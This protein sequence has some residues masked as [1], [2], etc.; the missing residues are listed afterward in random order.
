MGEDRSEYESL[1]GYSI[2]E[3]EPRMAVF[4]YPEYEF[5][6]TDRLTNIKIDDQS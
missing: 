1:Y 2:G 6:I 3:T 5:N 4:E